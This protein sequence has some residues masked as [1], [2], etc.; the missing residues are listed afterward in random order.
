[1]KHVICRPL[2]LSVVLLLTLTTGTIPALAKGPTIM[3]V[4]GRPLAKTI[5]VSNMRDTGEFM[6]AANDARSVPHANLKGRPYFRVAMFW[7]IRWAHYMQQHKR[8]AAL[9]PRQADQFARLFPAYGS[10]PALFVFDSIP[11]PYRSLIRGIGP[12]G[13]AVLARDGIPVRLPK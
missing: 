11:G 9:S 1:M 6:V 5:I 8:L 12:R 2:F 13:L 7:D 10:A 4:Y 3:M